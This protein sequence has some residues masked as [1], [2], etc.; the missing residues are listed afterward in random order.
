MVEEAKAV[1][2][3]HDAVA[4]TIDNVDAIEAAILEVRRQYAADLPK[5]MIAGLEASIAK[6]RASL[7]SSE[8]E[9]A[10]LKKGG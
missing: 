1:G 5:R 2:T 3:A 9:L 7:A 6:Q 10:R 4:L 8:A